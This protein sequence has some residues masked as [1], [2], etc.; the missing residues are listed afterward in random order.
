MEGTSY[1]IAGLANKAVGKVKQVIAEVIG[2]PELKEEGECQVMRG[3]G[4]RSL[5]EA[6][7]ASEE[8]ERQDRDSAPP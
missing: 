3:E 6:K 8:D 4:Q 7:A 1:V 2:S 5:G